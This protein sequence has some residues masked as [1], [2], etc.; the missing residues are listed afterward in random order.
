V[1]QI[2]LRDF[3]EAQAGLRAAYKLAEK[4]DD[5]HA[6]VNASALSARIL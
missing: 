4:I 6:Q 1:A 2:G 3:E 5:Y